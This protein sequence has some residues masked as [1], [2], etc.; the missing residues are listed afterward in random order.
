VGEAEDVALI[1]DAGGLTAWNLD[2]FT[3]PTDDP[4]LC[5]RLAA[6]NALSDLH[7]KGARPE[8]AM[9][10]IGIPEDGPA[11]AMRQVM[12]GAREVLDAEGVRLVGGHTIRT[13]RLL[14]GFSVTG[15]GEDPIPQRGARPGDALILTRALGTGV[16]LRA[17]QAGLVSGAEV[18]AL[19]AQI[20]RPQIQLRLLRKAYPIYAAT[21]ITGFGLA[22]HLRGMLAGE[23]R[24]GGVS[25]RLDLSA[26][27]ALPGA[28]RLLAA[29]VRSSFHAQN[30]RGV[31]HFAQPVPEDLRVELL[32]DPQTAG[33]V[34]LA[35]AP[36]QAGWFEGAVIAGDAAADAVLGLR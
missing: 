3:A 6:L 16:L 27:P 26:L 18:Q 17:E 25:A 7:V 23:G 4:W 5:G 1:R 9:A 21:D 36:E 34:L 32:F 35:A 10:I 15:P 30:A 24:A 31:R 8:L 28:L 22:G 19:L 20:L 2:A 12:R 13:E 14:A 29:G 11:E 33:G